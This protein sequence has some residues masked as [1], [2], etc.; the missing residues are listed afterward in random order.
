MK[1]LLTIGNETYLLPEQKN[2]AQVLELLKGVQEVKSKTVYGPDGDNRYSEEHGYCTKQ[3]LA[4][5]QAKI[6]VELVLDDEVCTVT[7]FDAA[8]Q[9]VANAERAANGKP[10]RLL[11]VA[12]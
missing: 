9:K 6:R 3:V 5:N 12:A 8:V 7:Q 10:Q 2:L 11:P 4:T 1:T